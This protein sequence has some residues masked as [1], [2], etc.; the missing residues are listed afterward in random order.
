MISDWHQA[1]LGNAG[2][3]RPSRDEHWLGRVAFCTW[4]AS[5]LAKAVSRNKRLEGLNEG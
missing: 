4:M 2:G 3:R 5:R 1:G